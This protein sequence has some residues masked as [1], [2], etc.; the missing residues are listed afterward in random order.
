MEGVKKI[1]C[2]RCGDELDDKTAVWLEL[3]NHT[4]TYHKDGEVPEEKSQGFFSFGAA[5]SKKVL[6]NKGELVRIKRKK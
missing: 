6:K 3:N 1:F 2:E 4:G 5:C